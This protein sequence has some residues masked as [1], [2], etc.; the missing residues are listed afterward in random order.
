MYVG[1]EAYE[2]KRC[3]FKDGEDAAPSKFSAQLRC[4]PTQRRLVCSL[5]ALDRALRHGRAVLDGLLAQGEEGAAA[6]DDVL[7]VARRNAVPDDLDGGGRILEHGRLWSR[8][9]TLLFSGV[10]PAVSW[11]F[12]FPEGT[13][14]SRKCVFRVDEGRTSKVNVETQH[15]RT[16]Y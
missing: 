14:L 4:D 3:R 2:R 11:R 16:K 9:R 10:P 13:I 8:C 6:S 1:P 15:C 5:Q 12:R 7:F